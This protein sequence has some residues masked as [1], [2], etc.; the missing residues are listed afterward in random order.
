M[1]ASK[2]GGSIT[3]AGF[4]KLLARTRAE[5]TVGFPIHLHMLR[6]GCGYKLANAGHDTRAIQQHYLENQ[7]IQHAVRYIG[8]S[9]KRFKRFLGEPG[10]FTA[11]TV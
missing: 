2:H 4:R 5:S 7:N 10:V 3:A 1:F 11:S 6:H 9:V 8:L